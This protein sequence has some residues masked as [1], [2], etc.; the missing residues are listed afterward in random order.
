M[1][2]SN[3]WKMEVILFLRL[4][5]DTVKLIELKYWH[6]DN[7]YYVNNYYYLPIPYFLIITVLP[8]FCFGYHPLVFNQNTICNINFYKILNVLLYYCTKCS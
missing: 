8:E 7:T 6:A 2:Y 4:M 3:K 1:W 5:A